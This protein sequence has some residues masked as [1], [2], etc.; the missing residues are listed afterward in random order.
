MLDMAKSVSDFIE[1]LTPIMDEKGITAADIARTKLVTDSAISL[2]FSMKT[3]SVTVEMCRAI[4]KATDTPLPTVYR[5][6][7]I[8]PPVPES[9]ELSEQIIYETND[10]TTREKEEVLAYIQLRKNLR[11][12]NGNR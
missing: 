6:A 3:K 9:N 11:K 12:K 7:G 4:S 1:W 2:L 8:L 5:A 10:L